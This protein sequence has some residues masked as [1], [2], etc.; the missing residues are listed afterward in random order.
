MKPKYHI[1]ISCIAAVLL[2]TLAYSKKE[3]NNRSIRWGERL[4]TWE[5]FPVVKTIA[6]DFDAKIYSDIQFE[7]NR[8]DNFLR[9]YAR[10]LPQRS[11]RVVSGDDIYAQQLLIHEQYHFNVTEYFARLFRKEVIGIGKKNLTND[12]LQHLGK[13]Y[14]Q[15]A[16]EMQNLYDKESAHNTVKS[17]QRYWELHIAG[18]LRETAYYAEEDIYQYQEFVDDDTEWF[19]QIYIT[20]EGEVLSS[21]PENKKNSN[22]GEVYNIVRK[23]DSTIVKFYKNGILTAGGNLEAPICIFTTPRSSILEQHYFDET[24]EYFSSNT[25]API[26]RNH[27][28][29]NGNI[30]QTY[31]DG[32]GNQISR[33]GI[34]SRKGKWNEAQKSFYLSFYDENGNPMRQD[35]VFHEL[36][37]MDRNKRTK[38]ISY[39]DKTGEPM[40][41]DSFISI[42]EYEIDGQ[43]NVS[44]LKLFDINGELAT[45]KNGYHTIYDYDERGNTKAISF[46]DKAGNKTVDENRIHKYT[47]SYDLYGHATDIRKFNLRDYATNGIEEFHQSVNLF[48]SLGRITFRAEYYPDYILKFSADKTGASIYEYMGD[49]IKIIKSVDVYGTEATN[50][51]GISLI[52]QS[53]NTKQEVIRE[54]FFNAEGSW[55]KTEDGVTSY[56]YK[57]DER[58]NQI[59]QIT[60]DSLGK[61]QAVQEDVAIIRWE[62]NKQNNKTKT[63]YFTTENE[64]ANAKQG[65]TYNMYKWGENQNLLENSYFDKH[66]KPSLFDGIHKAS[67]IQNRFGK[68]SIVSMYDIDDQFIKGTSVIKYLY[69]DYGNMVSES[70]YDGKGYPILNDKGVHK[71]VYHWDE[72]ARYIGYSYKGKYGE[73]INDSTGTSSFVLSLNSS[74]YVHSYHYLDKYEKPVL[75]PDGYHYRENHYN[76]MDE[77][78]R[79]ST[80]G[81]DKKLI[82]NSE[83]IADYVYRIN[84]SG[85]ITR[86]SFFDAEGNLTEDSEGIA[87]YYYLP[88]L[89]GLY[90]LEKQLNSKGE[91]IPSSDT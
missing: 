78:S 67:Y 47:F 63:T 68:D 48:D 69:N 50:D 64:L 77:I 36:R 65:V 56:S 66:M 62:Y 35:G 85:Q 17:K 84:S 81:I 24:G 10:M 4:L 18:L 82:N 30:T 90:F 20:V 42:Y 44:S 46:L 23:K 16:N 54:D 11:G 60:F 14:I 45:Y 87:E 58:G 89:N 73:A 19:R 34:F 91:E 51:S 55:A 15:K 72:Y 6:G 57:Y 39:F 13:K 8:D 7:G 86:L 32:A 31:F 22:Y 12:D 75:G 2:I 88:D 49:S 38:R 40:R 61:T 53:L 59:E 83:G 33:K 37:E 76:D 9:I 1:F 28:D 80:Y 43:N 29:E 21:Y 25:I 26:V 41:N 3:E 5:D 70:S 74:G 27:K 52:K 79:T 71:T